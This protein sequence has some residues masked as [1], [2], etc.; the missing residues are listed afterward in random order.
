M[1][2]SLLLHIANEDSIVVD[3]DE[4]PDPTYEYIV[5]HNP[6]TRDNKDLHYI[7]DDVV[8]ILYPWHRLTFVEVMPSGEEGDVSTP[9]REQ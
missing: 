2:Y 6:R 5:C 3:V 4:L 1:A 9:F 7:Q 8:T